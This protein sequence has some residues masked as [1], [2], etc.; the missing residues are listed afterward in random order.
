MLLR[1]HW[2]SQPLDYWLLYRLHLDDLLGIVL[3]YSI[4]KLHIQ[5]LLLLELSATAAS[6]DDRL[7]KVILGLSIGAHAKLVVLLVQ[8]GNLPHSLSIG[9]GS[10]VKGSLNGGHPTTKARFVIRDLYAIN[11][12]SL[13]THGVICHSLGAPGGSY[14]PDLVQ[15]DWHIGYVND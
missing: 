12:R 13:I 2:R 1:I 3:L 6:V 10:L 15:G 8:G 5:S 4:L 14:D 7:Q 11:V 9:S